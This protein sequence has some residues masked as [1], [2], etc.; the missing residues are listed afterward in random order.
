MLLTGS[1]PLGKSLKSLGFSF[2]IYEVGVLGCKGP[3]AEGRL[4][5]QTHFKNTAL[6]MKL[7]G[8]KKK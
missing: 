5:K 7:I 2:L 1:V 4:C 6:Q 3:G 8:R